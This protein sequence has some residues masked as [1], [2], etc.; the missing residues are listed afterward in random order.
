MI[1]P[2]RQA[3]H[4]IGVVFAMVWAPL[5]VEAYTEIFSEMHAWAQIGYSAFIGAAAVVWW[6]DRCERKARNQNDG[7]EWVDYRDWRE[8]RDR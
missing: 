8:G 7:S 6:L 1:S 3:G 4:A 2:G 5:M